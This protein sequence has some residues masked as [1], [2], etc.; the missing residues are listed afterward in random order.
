VL[1]SRVISV[2]YESCIEKFGVCN[3]SPFCTET[4]K[5]VLDWI[6][7]SKF[8]QV[9]SLRFLAVGGLAIK[10]GLKTADLIDIASFIEPCRSIIPFL[11]RFNQRG[12]SQR[13]SSIQRPVM[14]HA[15]PMH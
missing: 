3:I 2:T 10:D 15:G 9:R 8:S 5:A 7:R 12:S 1:F 4:A 11:R 13:T 14:H 6:K